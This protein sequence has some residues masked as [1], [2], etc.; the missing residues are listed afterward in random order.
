[1]IFIGTHPKELGYLGAE[2]E[3]ALGPEGEKV[4]FNLPTVITVPKGIPH[5]PPVVK[6]IEKPFGFIIYNLAPS[7]RLVGWTRALAPPR[8]ISFP[9]R[10]PLMN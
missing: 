3:I 1:M 2:I 4:T 10:R 7:T 8:F 6:K 9:T 5:R